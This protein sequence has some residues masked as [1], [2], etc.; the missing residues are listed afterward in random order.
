MLYA[1]V[2]WTRADDGGT[3]ACGLS[4]RHAAVRR[5]EGATRNQA[6]GRLSLSPDPGHFGKDPP[7]DP[8]QKPQQNW[9]GSFL[10][11]AHLSPLVS[12]SGP[13]H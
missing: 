3:M 7:R 5:S 12:V 13:R 6:S 2:N 9:R 8:G 10:M 11:T 1:L 4:V